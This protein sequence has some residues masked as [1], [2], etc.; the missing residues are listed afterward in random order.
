[1]NLNFLGFDK[2]L[3]PQLITRRTLSTLNRTRTS[4]LKLHL[5]SDSMQPQTAKHATRTST[6]ATKKTR[7]RRNK[8]RRRGKEKVVRVAGAEKEESRRWFLDLGFLCISKT[9]C[10]RQKTP[11][12]LVK[13]QKP[14]LTKKQKELRK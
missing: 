14:T 10:Y 11:M 9:K 4:R 7:L 5:V 6:T 12:G 3:D 1:M 8:G 13:L 2:E